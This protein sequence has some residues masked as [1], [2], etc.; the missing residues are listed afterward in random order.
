MARRGRRRDHRGLIGM[1]YYRDRRAGCQGG[2]RT[3]LPAYAYWAAMFYKRPTQAAADKWRAVT[4][5]G[6]M[7]G[8]IANTDMAHMV[9]AT[10]QYEWRGDICYTS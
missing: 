3:V 7:R 9:N 5:F 10:A 1:K 4:C 2:Y 8:L 6:Y